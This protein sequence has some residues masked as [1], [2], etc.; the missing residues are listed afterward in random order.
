MYLITLFGFFGLLFY[1]SFTHNLNVGLYWDL[2]SLLIILFPTITLSFASFKINDIK[3]A[4]VTAFSSSYDEH[5]LRV[6]IDVFSFMKTISI[7]CGAL[8]TLA[9][10]I[11][12]FFS[13]GFR[14]EQTNYYET[15]GIYLGLSMITMFYGIFIAFLIFEP[16]KF[17]LKREF[18]KH[19]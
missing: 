8:G 1:Y 10:W 16:M 12:M 18:D 11:A 7:A 4:F 3:T 19:C 9:N 13:A 14:S 6:G 17:H 5:S 15:L 2:K